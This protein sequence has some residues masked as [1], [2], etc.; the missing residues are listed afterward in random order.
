MSIVEKTS[1]NYDEIPVT[2]GMTL[3]EQDREFLKKMFVEQDEIKEIIISELLEINT[4]NIITSI[5]EILTSHAI[6]TFFEL[7]YQENIVHAELK[8]QEE[9]VSELMEHRE[10]R[11]IEMINEIKKLIK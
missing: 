5:D 7:K 9:K 1:K 6:K 10:K 11:L 3:N 4:K 8:A 2:D